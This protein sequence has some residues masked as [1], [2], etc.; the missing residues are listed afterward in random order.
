M[1]FIY[2][3]FNYFTL[4]PV[5]AFIIAL[6]LVKVVNNKHLNG[7][8]IT[9]IRAVIQPFASKKAEDRRTLSAPDVAYVYVESLQNQAAVAIN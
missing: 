8:S 1:V 7:P 2:F 3:N 6:T 5:I 9:A 4:I